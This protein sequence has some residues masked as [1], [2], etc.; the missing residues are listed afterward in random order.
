MALSLSDAVS[1]HNEKHA[2]VDIIFK[3]RKCHK[4][5]RTKH[6]A[7]CH[8]P[9]CPGAG[10][11]SPDNVQAKP[12]SCPEC[13]ESFI[14]QRV[15]SQHKRLRHP[16]TRNA[17]RIALVTP[18]ARAPRSGSSFSTEEIARMYEL[19]R[20]HKGDPDIVQKILEGLENK[21]SKQIRDKRREPAY[22]R[23]RDQYLKD[24]ANV[25]PSMRKRS[26][27][28]LV[29]D[30]SGSSIDVALRSG[31]RRR[32]R[33]SSTRAPYEN[34]GLTMTTT[35][36]PDCDLSSLTTERG[37]PIPGC[38]RSVDPDANED[39]AP[40]TLMEES[41]QQRFLPAVKECY[42]RLE[43]CDNLIPSPVLGRGTFTDDEMRW[44]ETL[45]SCLE[46]WNPS[47]HLKDSR[48]VYDAIREA[49]SN[50][51]EGS[52]EAAYAAVAEYFGS[53][54]EPI[55]TV[56]RP[57]R[58]KQRTKRK[59][60]RYQ[61]ARAQELFK[62]DPGLLARH[63]RQGT[64]YAA[65]NTVE[66]CRSEVRDL[67]S[68]LWGT[69]TPTRIPDVES[70]DIPSIELGK[71]GPI[72]AIDIKR[73][74]AGIK[75]STAPGLDGIKRAVLLGTRKNEMLAT[76]FNLILA[77][78]VLP[79]SWRRNRTTLIPKE[80]KDTNKA[81]NYRPLT[82]GSLLS[83]LFWGIMDGRLRSVIPMSPRQKGFVAEAGC[84]NNIQILHELTCQMKQGRGGVGVQLDVS[85]AF[86]TVP[87]DAIPFALKRKGVPQPIVDL[88]CKSYEN[89]VTT[90]SHPSGGIEIGL[91]RGVKQGDPLSP[92]LFNLVLEPVLDKLEHM[93][94]YP[95]PE[96]KNISCLAFADDL[97]L[98][99]SDSQKAQALLDCVVE[100][101]GALGMTIAAS[102]S[103]AY[104]IEA[105]RDSWYMVDPG[106]ERIGDRIPACTPESGITY[107]GCRYSVWSGFDLSKINDH[108]TQVIA[109]IKALKLKPIQKIQLLQT[110]MVPHY[111]HQ[112][113]VA[114]PPKALLLA[115]DQELRVA[116][117]QILH[118]PQ[119]I[120]NGIIYC[121]KTDGGLGFPRLQELVPRVSL[122]A[123][124][125]FTESKDPAVGALF[126]CP[127]TTARMRKTANSVRINY[128]Y[129][130]ADVGRFKDACRKTELKRWKDLV[131]QGQ[132]VE[133]LAGDKIGNSFLHDPALLK[134]CRFITA[135]QLRTNTAGNRTSLNRAIPQGDLRCRKCKASKETLAHIL[136]QCIHTKAARI[137]RHNEIRDFIENRTLEKD[138]SAI[139]SKEPLIPLAEGGNLKPDLIVKNQI[140]VFVV[141]VTVRHEDGD[142]LHKAKLEKEEKY[143][144]IL[145]NL[146]RQFGM[147]KGEV[148]PIVVGTRGAMPKETNSALATLGLKQA[149]D[150][151]TISLMAL[152]SSI[153]LY[154]A[155]LDY[156]GALL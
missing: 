142:S 105:T 121:G 55:Q 89:V 11:G 80:G 46:D 115:M 68:A 154:H 50:F 150:L 13:T 131:A 85:K 116:F 139:V 44:K 77:S 19:E 143:K 69:K 24:A 130:K 95:L 111:L 27:I 7:L 149:G 57:P 138:A 155:F 72:T 87:H 96:D 59:F 21:T 132:A 106:L 88:I 49:I 78:G 123:G 10:R 58:N 145:P 76:M 17:E 65:R 1:H 148:L 71:F 61:Y 135:L 18:A 79:A 70:D 75:K 84:F 48:K 119:S 43:R 129:T 42:V 133:S 62:R 26:R 40:L 6:A 39:Q 156:D 83:R 38:S 118:L 120:C 104:Q 5:Y 82:I 37:E 127:Q 128:P 93:S 30:S 52:I 41:I 100:E 153:E 107:L 97:F 63:V 14:T 92:L 25:L 126:G 32:T 31:T 137:R 8:I 45:V 66:V 90:I 16:A 64:D 34:S 152:R 112:L 3:C 108:L 53:M 110:Y 36:G 136:G 20:I 114:M 47:E 103:C 144:K 60:K 28:S 122:L 86:D 9:K 56:D 102:K 23:R 140:G 151:K 109:R 134:P 147:E 2:S 124:L 15:L 67:Y 73:R 12:F 33:P 54:Q 74:L 117:K 125:K 29:S 113:V 99:A 22:C 81:T 4:P 101:L 91:R 98:F 35:G 141:D 94:G 51:N 146:L